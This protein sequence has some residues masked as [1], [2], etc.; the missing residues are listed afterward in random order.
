MESA[1]TDTA[2]PLPATVSRCEPCPRRLGCAL[3]QSMVALRTRRA[4]DRLPDDLLQDVGVTRGEIPFVGVRARR[5]D[6]RCVSSTQ[7]ERGG[8]GVDSSCLR[9]DAVP[10]IRPLDLGQGVLRRPA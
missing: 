6:P 9:A 7:P 5:S 1:M 4:L 10:A 3:Y 8:D 2:V